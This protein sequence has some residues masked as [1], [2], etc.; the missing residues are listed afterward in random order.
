MYDAL[1]RRFPAAAHLSMTM[2]GSTAPPRRES[3]PDTDRA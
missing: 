1:A 2:N 3:L